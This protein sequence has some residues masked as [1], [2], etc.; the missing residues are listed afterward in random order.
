MAIGF[1]RT[2]VIDDLGKNG[3]VSTKASREYV[4]DEMGDKK[5]EGND[6]DRFFKK[7]GNKEGRR[8]GMWRSIMGLGRA[9]QKWEIL[10]QIYAD[11]TGSIEKQKLKMQGETRDIIA[12][13]RSL[14]R[15]YGMEFSV[16]VKDRNKEASP[17]KQERS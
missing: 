4:E 1:G 11:W 2:E 17:T 7:F 12:E 10:Q 14:P 9:L 15:Q 16:K 5:V 13:D 3:M 6:L 8:C